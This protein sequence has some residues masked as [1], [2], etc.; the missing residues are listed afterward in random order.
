MIPNSQ[1]A[2][3]FGVTLFRLLGWVGGLDLTAIG[4]DL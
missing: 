3:R 4:L 2:T 1:A